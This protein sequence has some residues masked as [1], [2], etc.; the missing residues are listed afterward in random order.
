M[1]EFVIALASALLIS[2][3]KPQMVR[4]TR[5]SVYHLTLLVGLLLVPSMKVTPPSSIQPRYTAK[6]LFTHQSRATLNR[7]FTIFTLSLAP[8]VTHIAFGLARHVV[9]RS[10]DPKWTDS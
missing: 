5:I 4:T 1:E 3:E 6:V 9:L 7:W 10:E 8:L 2:T